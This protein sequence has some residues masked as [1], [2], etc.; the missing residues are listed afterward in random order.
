M[1]VSETVGALILA[2]GRSSRMGDA[3]K[4]LEIWDGKPLVAHVADAIADAGLPPPLVV[5][6]HR[7]A[8]VAAALG[9]RRVRIVIAADFA[10]GLSAS[11]RTGIAAVPA[12]WQAVLVCLGDMPRVTAA[13]LRQLAAAPGE[14]IVPTFEARR[15]NPVRWPRA[16]FSALAGLS[17]DT[18]GRA[19]LARLPVI[20]VAV[21]DPGV[22]ADVDTPADLAALIAHRSAA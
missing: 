4:L 19:L 2:A 5:V 12:D 7:A 21:D 6:G 8:E 14:I 20:D 10:D 11:L 9:D 15:G 16:H 1:T 17:G 3:H 22:L 13:T 18:G